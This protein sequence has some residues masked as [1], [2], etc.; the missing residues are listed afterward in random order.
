MNGERKRKFIDAGDPKPLGPAFYFKLETEPQ[1]ILIEIFDVN[2]NLMRTYQK[3]EMDLSFGKGLENSLN[4]FVWD[5]RINPLD[6]VPTRPP[7]GIS[8]I[9][10]PGEYSVKLTADGVTEVQSFHLYMNPKEP[11]TNA[12]AQAKFEF[13]MEMYNSAELYTQ[14]VI[15]ALETRDAV[16]A[17][18]EELEKSGMSEDELSKIRQQAEVVTKLSNAFEAEFVSTG[19]TLAEIINLPATIFYKMSYV[20]GNLDITEGPVSTNQKKAF[21]DAFEQAKEVDAKFQETI[22]PELEKFNELTN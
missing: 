11:F 10:P 8:P 17:K 13:W 7:T 15:T 14:K 12:Q 4:K 16:N 6:V 22:K 1:E 20:S 19:R 3:S 5:M 2:G 18:V 9:V 21:Y